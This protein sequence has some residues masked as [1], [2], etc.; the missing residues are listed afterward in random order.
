M[1]AKMVMMIASMLGMLAV[2]AA[3]EIY[4]FPGD[5]GF[6]KPLK[7][8][9]TPNGADSEKDCSIIPEGRNGN[10]LQIDSQNKSSEVYSTQPVQINQKTDKIRFSV[11]VKGSGKFNVFLFCYAPTYIGTVSLIHGKAE[12]KWKEY[13]VEYQ[14]DGKQFKQE[15]LK[16]R[17]AFNVPKGSKV[18]FDDM[19]CE[20]ISEE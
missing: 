16:V 5:S 15:D 4:T 19:V 11:Y 6:E 12:E 13:K 10:A 14:F 8:G 1:K 18:V 17:V 3:E 20:R 9:W 2:N 7:T